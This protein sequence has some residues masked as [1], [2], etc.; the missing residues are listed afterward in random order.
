MR[1]L[2]LWLAAAGLAEE[3]TSFDSASGL[4][5]GWVTPIL[6]HNVEASKAARIN[7]ELLSA[8]S[9][10]YRRWNATRD[11]EQVRADECAVRRPQSRKGGRVE[12]NNGFYLYQKASPILSLAMRA[13]RELHEEIDKAF[14][15]YPLDPDAS[16]QGVPRTDEWIQNH[17]W[18]TH[19]TGRSRGHPL[20]EHGRYAASGVYFVHAP[21]GSADLQFHDPRCMPGVPSPH[22]PLAPQP[23][24]LVLFPSWLRHAVGHSYIEGDEARVSIAFNIPGRWEERIGLHANLGPVE[25]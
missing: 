22:T 24:K 14:R 3:D 4:V 12:N 16:A 17:V 10:H 25:D 13:V 23:G 11:A 18:A 15:G 6:I 5:G 2:L 19:H 21:E 7:R 20:H 1:L 8:V 9:E